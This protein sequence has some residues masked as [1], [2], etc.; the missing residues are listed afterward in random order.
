MGGHNRSF[1]A[2]WFDLFS[3]LH[4]NAQSDS[5]ICFYCV[6]QSARGNQR[7]ATKKDQAFISDGFCNWKKSLVK[8]SQHESSACHKMAIDYAVNYPKSCSNVIEMTNKEREKVRQTNRRCLI[9]IIENLQCLYR[10]GLAV[11]ETLIQNRTFISLLNLGT[12]MTLHYLSWLKNMAVI[13][14]CPTMYKMN[15][16]KL[17]LIRFNET[18]QKILEQGF[19]SNS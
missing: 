2:S 15:L 10:Q 18:L 16:L 7:C 6:Q 4:Y 1:Q 17:W 5:V 11:Q 19:F 13:N 9:K 12:E 14:I 3:W 8:F